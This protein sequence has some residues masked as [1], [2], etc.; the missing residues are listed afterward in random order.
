[1]KKLEQNVNKLCS[2]VKA[3]DTALKKYA[4]Y[5]RK[6][7]AKQ[8]ND[9]I[10]KAVN[11]GQLAPKDEETIGFWKASLL[12]N[13]NK[14]ALALSKLPSNPVLKKVTASEPKRRTIL[15]R[16]GEQNILIADA[17]KA[18]PNQPFSAIYAKAKLENPKLF[19]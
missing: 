4:A 12:S 16:L 8:A 11:A 3:Q 7:R 14:T 18:M 15:N 2:V 10:A 9:A 13:F 6:I 17:K 5:H 1:M 19:S